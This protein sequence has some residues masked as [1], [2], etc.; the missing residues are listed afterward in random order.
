MSSERFRESWDIS[1]STGH[2]WKS[3]LDACDLRTLKQPCIQNRPDSVIQSLRGLR[4]TFRNHCLWTPFHPQMQL[5]ALTCKVETICERDPET[6]PS[7]LHQSLLK[8]D[9][10]KVKTV[11][12]SD[13]IN[14][15]NYFW[16]IMDTTSPRLKT[17]GSFWLGFSSQFKS[18]SDGMEVH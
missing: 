8:M 4:N 5:K 7:F 1:V 9:W 17:R 3:I 6:L 14:S 2:G 12:W 16:K 11:L 15:K 10:S 13:K 18:I